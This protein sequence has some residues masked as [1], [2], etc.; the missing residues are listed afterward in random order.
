MDYS[1]ILVAFSNT[2]SVLFS[3]E[4]L[5]NESVYTVACTD[6]LGDAFFCEFM[7]HY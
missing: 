3:K 1:P 6:R 2:K 4:K 7:L 5:L